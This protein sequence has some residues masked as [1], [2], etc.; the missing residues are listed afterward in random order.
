MIRPGPTFP[1][2]VATVFA[3]VL[4]T[5][6]ATTVAALLAAPAAQ[7]QTACSGQRDAL[8]TARVLTVEPAATP[9]VGRKHFSGTLPLADMEVVLTFDDGPRP[10]RTDRVLDALARECVRASFFVLGKH[11]LAHPALLRRIAAEGHT[12][13]HHTFGHP[14]LDRMSTTAAE[15]EIDHGIAAVETALHGRPSERPTTPFFRFPGFASTPA[16]LDRLQQ[17]GIVVFG[18]DLWASDWT[19]MAPGQQL[20]L[21]LARLEASRGGILLFH[22]PRLQT[23]QMLPAFLRALKSRGFRIVHVVPPSLRTAAG[24]R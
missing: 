13:A 8:G 10:G 3:T 15:R 2:T 11:A 1:T 18:A 20:D 12:V 6:L 19:D 22:D 16:L 14:L 23:V 5:M 7:A 17:R 21:V 24:P 9:R 4:V